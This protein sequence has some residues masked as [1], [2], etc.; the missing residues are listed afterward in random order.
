MFAGVISHDHTALSALGSSVVGALD[1]ERSA[2]DGVQGVPATMASRRTEVTLA[3]RSDSSHGIRDSDRRYSLRSVVHLEKLFVSVDCQRKS[4]PE[5]AH[6][7]TA[8]AVLDR[9]MSENPPFRCQSFHILKQ[10]QFDPAHQGEEAITPGACSPKTADKIISW[11]RRSS[12]G[13]ADRA[14]GRN[15]QALGQVRPDPATLRWGLLPE[16][17]QVA[18]LG[19]VEQTG[20]HPQ[21]WIW[22]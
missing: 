8:V 2:P 11:L 18:G 9:R 16:A 1:L 15:Y 13:T 12:S 7:P 19:A 5:H 22:S 17:L 3:R 20:E 14:K 10:H 4:S 21:K 6:K